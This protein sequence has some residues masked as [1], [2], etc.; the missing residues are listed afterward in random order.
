MSF[1]LTYERGKEPSPLDPSS[2]Y[3]VVRQREGSMDILDMDEN[4]NE[5]PAKEGYYYKQFQ[6]EDGSWYG[7]DGWYGPFI[8]FSEMPKIVQETGVTQ[9]I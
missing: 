9:N 6:F 7:V 4:G 3:D 1:G 5:F 2:R 8:S